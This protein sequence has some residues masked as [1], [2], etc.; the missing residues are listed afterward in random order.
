MHDQDTLIASFGPLT[1][2]HRD[3]CTDGTDSSCDHKW[4]RM[5][6]RQR[7]CVEFCVTQ[8]CTVAAESLFYVREKHPHPLEGFRLA[9][10]Y[11]EIVHGCLGRPVRGADWLVLRDEIASWSWR[12]MAFLPG[13]HSNG[14]SEDPECWA[15]RQ[16][17][18]DVARVMANAIIRSKKPWWV[19]RWYHVHH[20]RFHL[21]PFWKKQES[22]CCTSSHKTTSDPTS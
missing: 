8:D 3:P 21:R 6:K 19:A 2:W 14:D 18:I 16:H 10:M 17:R 4:K 22:A 13:Y 7:N 9:Q 12:S 5:S 20:W 11:L 15:F 1:L